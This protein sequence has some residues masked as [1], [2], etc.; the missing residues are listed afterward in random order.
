MLG[1]LR[2]DITFARHQKD[3]ENAALDWHTPPYHLAHLE[4]GK[5][6]QSHQDPTIGEALLGEMSDVSRVLFPVDA[7][8]AIRSAA[9]HL[10][11]STH[12]SAASSSQKPAVPVV[13]NGAQAVRSVEQGG[14]TVA[15]TPE[16]ADIQLVAI[17]AYQLQQALQALPRLAERG[18]RGTV[19]VIV[20]PG[21]FRIPRDEIESRFV[22]LGAAAIERLFP[23]KLP[24]M[25][26]SHT[27]GPSQ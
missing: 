7:N 18:L 27:P 14:V 5:N 25:L 26:S 6:E 1:A 4:N 11:P 12:R 3:W 22:V 15:D 24:R 20:E 2:Q 21:R 19:A 23:A 16:H 10:M 9:M 8:S 17:G 13:L